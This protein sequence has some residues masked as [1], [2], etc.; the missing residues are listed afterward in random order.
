MGF[1]Q[2]KIP[3]SYVAFRWRIL[4]NFIYFIRWVIYYKVIVPIARHA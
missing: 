1:K 2:K 3:I 4:R